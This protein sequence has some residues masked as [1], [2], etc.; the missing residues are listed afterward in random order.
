MKQRWMK[1][2]IEASRIE[3]TVMPFQRGPRL[4]RRQIAADA[5]INRSA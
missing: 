5:R 1:S 3:T 4:P 2:V